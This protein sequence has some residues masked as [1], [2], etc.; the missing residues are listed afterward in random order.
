MGRKRRITLT[1]ADAGL[2]PDQITDIQ[3]KAD[4]V[5]A[6]T[7]PEAS[8]VEWLDEAAEDGPADRP[9]PRAGSLEDLSQRRDRLEAS[10]L[11][12]EAD[13]LGRVINEQQARRRT[14]EAA[15]ARLKALAGEG[16]SRDRLA[17]IILRSDGQLT[18]WHYEVA[19]A[20]RAEM[21]ARLGSKIPAAP[22]ATQVGGRGV[23]DRWTGGRRVWGV[24]NEKTVK[25]RPPPTFDP[26]PVRAARKAGSTADQ[27]FGAV[28]IKRR[29]EAL[30]SEFGAGVA[31]AGCPDWTIG[32]ALRVVLANETLKAVIDSAPGMR[33]A[34]KRAAVKKALASGLCAVAGRL[35]LSALEG[36]V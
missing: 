3:A 24:R 22:E 1:A 9:G 25:L 4:A 15:R 5:K 31:A 8:D 36:P 20:L 35:G 14:D 29:C 30:L 23:L 10:G 34:D 33:D 27:V 19:E 7:R 6:W 13:Q 28:M 11:Y 16:V 32:A 17:V 12:A 21:Q 18:A 2:S 26:K